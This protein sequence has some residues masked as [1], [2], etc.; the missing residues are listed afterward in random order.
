MNFRDQVKAVVEG[1]GGIKKLKRKAYAILKKHGYDSKE[2]KAAQA[3]VDHKDVEGRQ[4]QLDKSN[5]TD[6]QQSPDEKVKAI[7]AKAEAEGRELTDDERTEIVVQAGRKI[8]L[9]K[10]KAIQQPES[11]K[12]SSNHPFYQK[13]KALSRGK[14]SQSIVEKRKEK[15]PSKLRFII[16]TCAKKSKNVNE[17]GPPPLWR[18]RE[19]RDYDKKAK[20]KAQKIM[21]RRP[22]LDD[23]DRPRNID[24]PGFEA[25]HGGGERGD[26]RKRDRRKNTGLDFLYYTGPQRRKRDRRKPA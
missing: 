4:R 9:K 2:Y 22:N 5:R 16:A 15:E 10:S 20:K 23:D 18:S 24:D 25:Q 12:E 7:R 11:Q 8:R 13:V 19:E 21:K 26:R 3:R 17:D 14:K 6:E 1:S